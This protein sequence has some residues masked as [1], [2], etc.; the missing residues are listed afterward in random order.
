M[1]QRVAVARALVARPEILLLDEPFGALDWLLR[2]HIIV[3]F[4]DVWLA[5]KSTTV[6]VT[7]ETREAAFLADR[8]LVFS[9]RPGRI[10]ATIDVPFPRPRSSNIFT[11]EQ[12]HSLC[13]LID[14]KCESGI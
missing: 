1:A 9:P 5:E 7:H 2:R 8:I 14:E 12:F 4:E 10:L 6:I 11:T 13:D 3:D